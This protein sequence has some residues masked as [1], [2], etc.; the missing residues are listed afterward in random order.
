MDLKVDD[1]YDIDPTLLLTYKLDK[2]NLD[3]LPDDI[4]EFDDKLDSISEYLSEDIKTSQTIKSECKFA[5]LT[6]VVDKAGDVA[7]KV[8]VPSRTTKRKKDINA[9]DEPVVENDLNQLL[10]KLELSD[11][12]NEQA[13]DK[14]NLKLKERGP[15][16]PRRRANRSR[17]LSNIWNRSE[18]FD[19]SQFNSERLRFWSGSNQVQTNE[20]TAPVQ[21]G[22]HSGSTV[23]FNRSEPAHTFINQDLFYEDARAISVSSPES[24]YDSCAHSLTGSPP[25]VLTAQSLDFIP[26]TVDEQVIL[27]FLIENTDGALP[28][29]NLDTYKADEKD[30]KGKIEEIINYLKDNTP[31]KLSD[32]PQPADPVPPVNDLEET[33][34]NSVKVNPAPCGSVPKS[35][36]TPK[37]FVLPK[38]E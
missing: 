23:V 35:A 36:D 8:E 14:D 2:L 37:K 6:T 30:A 20:A 31:L 9:N 38:L 17:D 15:D 33:V 13:D 19:R 4:P 22:T 11:S 26:E 29:N 32:S 24:G 25:P 1:I 10:V 18:N 5:G 7:I 28:D 34:V 12:D 21:F 16:R 27:D 3:I